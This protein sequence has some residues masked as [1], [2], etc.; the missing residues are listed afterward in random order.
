[1]KTLLLSI[2]IVILMHAIYGA[3]LIPIWLRG[4]KNARNK[5]Q[6]VNWE[7]WLNDKSI[8]KQVLRFELTIKEHASKTLFM[9][10]I[11]LFT[12]CAGVKKMQRA[13]DDLWY[14]TKA[15]IV[16]YRFKQFIYARSPGGMYTYEI[17]DPLDKWKGIDTISVM[18]HP[19]VRAKVNKI[20]INY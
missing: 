10:F 17:H 12:S 5:K 7:A 9:L 16:E 1:M 13:G 8:K 2:Q 4:R 6:I 11:V 14:N 18:K 20:E 15:F 19:E 3:L